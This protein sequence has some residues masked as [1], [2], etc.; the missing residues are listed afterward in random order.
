MNSLMIKP[1]ERR[2]VLLFA[3]AVMLVTSLPYIVAYMAEGQD[4]VFT[5]FLFGVEDGN[6]YIAKM[7]SGHNGDWLFRTPYTAIPQNGAVVF[8]PYLL[9][10]KLASFSNIHL[11]M[12]VIYHLFRL[13]AGVL[14]FL[15]T[16]IFISLFIQKVKLRRLA[17]AVTMLGGGLGWVVVLVW[18][19]WFGSIPLEFYSPETFGFLSI[20]G[21]PHL[22][23]ARALMLLGLAAYLNGRGVLAGMLWLALGFF[24]PVNVVVAWAVLGA[25]MVAVAINSKRNGATGTRSIWNGL[26]RFA[27][28]SLWAVSISSP[29][30][31][32][33][34]TI[35]LIDPVLRAWKWSGQ[36]IITSPHPIHYL[37]A[38]GL[39]LPFAIIGMRWVAKQSEFK[40]MLPF[41]WLM[42]LPILVYLPVDFQ[43]RLAEGVWVA[44]VILAV[45]A[46][47]HVRIPVSFSKLI[48]FALTFP[49]T[50]F[51]L[52]GGYLAAQSPSSPIFLPAEEVAAFEYIAE[53]APIESVVLSSFD[54]GNALPAWA[55]VRVVI[56][57]GPESIGLA[58]VRPRVTAFFQSS[59][60][61]QDRR[62][63]LVEF[64]VKYVFWG[65][66]E[67]SL[68]DWNPTNADYLN[69]IYQQDGYIIFEVQYSDVI[70]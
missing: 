28:Q 6:S 65:P 50:L 58:E 44:I 68:G 69:P 40:W 54:T 63:L 42:I 38:Y 70:N 2:W 41:A 4:W 57:H 46:I 53:V 7:L 47:E 19:E 17:L 52:L 23:F 27:R 14:S 55:L 59:S 22:V 49:S 32:Y 16:Y 24:Q 56:G 29:M 20:Y 11:N 15:A 51:L 25:H 36:N 26:K 37:V 45:I 8:L 33:S 66:G 3:F 35:F 1:V 62:E 34:A 10:G 12:M 31:I 39:L 43:R 67:Q 64:S 30:V 9:L 5:G 21:I 61:D 18:G 13:L 60:Q 48:P